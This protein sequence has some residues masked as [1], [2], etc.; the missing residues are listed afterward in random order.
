MADM[1]HFFEQ[2]QPH[3]ARYALNVLGAL[4][5]FFAGRFL[6]KVLRNVLER[7]L[8]KGQVDSTLASFIVQ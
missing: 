2:V 4:F 7:A 5:I 8:H 6:A 3:I 1:I